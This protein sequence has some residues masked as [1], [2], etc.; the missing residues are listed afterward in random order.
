MRTSKSSNI[1]AASDPWIYNPKT[2]L[3][4]RAAC[5]E[6]DYEGAPI[7]THVTRHTREPPRPADNRL[8]T[9]PSGCPRQEANNLGAL[10]AWINA[11]TDAA[12]PELLKEA[13]AARDSI[14]KDR[15]KALKREMTQVDRLAQAEALLRLLAN[16]NGISELQ[17]ALIEAQGFAGVAPSLDAEVEVAQE[18]LVDLRAAAKTSAIEDQQDFMEEHAVASALQGVHMSS[19]EP[20]PG[21]KPSAEERTRRTQILFN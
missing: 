8:V 2:L 6:G 13:R 21:R 4:L 15:K 18:R 16:E 7:R 11:Y 10:V 1:S 17:A 3:P 5:A 20:E 12:S 19:S 14:K 9:W